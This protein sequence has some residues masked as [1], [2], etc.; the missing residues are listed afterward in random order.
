[1]KSYCQR[2]EAFVSASKYIRRIT[3]YMHRFW[4]PQQINDHPEDIDVST[5]ATRR[6]L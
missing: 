1:M 5:Q 6:C 3:E 4:I 2:F